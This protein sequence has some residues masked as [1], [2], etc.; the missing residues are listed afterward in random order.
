ML[1]I[2]GHEAANSPVPLCIRVN[3]PTFLFPYLSAFLFHF[4]PLF[5]FPRWFLLNPSVKHWPILIIFG[6]QHYSIKVKWA[7]LQSF[8]S[9]FFILLRAKNYQNWPIFHNVI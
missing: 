6:M 5:P 2:R 1:S 3:L 9:S 7:K 8:T 4:F